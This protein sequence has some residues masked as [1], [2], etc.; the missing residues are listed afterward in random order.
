[1]K[2]FEVPI[3]ESFRLNGKTFIVKK[4]FYKRMPKLGKTLHCEAINQEGKRQ[5]FISN[6]D[7]EEKNDKRGNSFI[8]E[9]ISFD[10]L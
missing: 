6:W 3:G 10:S 7:V 2:L 5:L 4:H 9:S 1:M 8:R